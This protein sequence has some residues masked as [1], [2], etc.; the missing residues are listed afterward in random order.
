[1]TR[2]HQPREHESAPATDEHAHANLFSSDR[3]Q[4]SG[5]ELGALAI[6]GACDRCFWLKRHVE[7]G[8]PFQI[9]PGIFSSIDTYTKRVVQNYFDTKK[10][11]PAWLGKLESLFKVEIES[12]VKIPKE[13][14][15]YDPESNLL[16]TGVPD[17][18][19]RTKDGRIIIV[20]YKTS[21]YTKNQAGLF[22]MYEIQLNAYARIA[23]EVGLGEVAGLALIYCEPQTTKDDAAKP[24][25]INR[26]GFSMRF[27]PKIKPVAIDAE[28]VSTLINKARSVY[29]QE[30]APACATNCKDCVR[31]N[32]LSELLAKKT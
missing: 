25:A 7:S 29:D 14:R 27:T 30:S 3:M 20:D 10:T 26:E 31:V 4:I 24:K 15:L 6:D 12:I 8:L 16:L 21:R 28:K 1:M 9:F 13:F 23:T 18:I 11:P 32:E 5:K 2:S 22:P 19:F 17:D